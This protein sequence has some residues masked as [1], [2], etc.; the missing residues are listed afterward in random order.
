VD[1]DKEEFSYGFATRDAKAISSKDLYFTPEVSQ[2]G[3][4]ISMFVKLGPGQ[5]IEHHFELNKNNNLV[6]FKLSLV[7]M[8]AFIAPNNNFIDLSWKH[9][10][11]QQEKTHDAEAKTSTIYYRYANEE[12]E[13]L[14][15]TKD[16]K[17]D[18]KTP[19]QWVAFKQQYFNTSLISDQVFDNGVVESK[20]DET[21]KFV[22][23]L[24]AN[25]F[26]NLV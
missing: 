11:L 26:F 8:D 24:T 19:V 20:S 23:I 5:Y 15:E 6:D 25:M 21:K 12:P 13:Y 1:G 4:G 9:D 17:E 2:D 16:L 22:K 18:L 7:G 3:K 14:A 10:V